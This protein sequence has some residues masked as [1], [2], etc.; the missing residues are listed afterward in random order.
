M[1]SF[2]MKRCSVWWSRIQNINLLQL[3]MVHTIKSTPLSQSLC[4]RFLCL[5]F[6]LCLCRLSL[7]RTLCSLSDCVVS[8]SYRFFSSSLDLEYRP[9]LGPFR[10]MTDTGDSSNS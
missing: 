2:R 7:S 3:P 9:C 5:A 1:L 10:Y 8:V 4:I 6:L